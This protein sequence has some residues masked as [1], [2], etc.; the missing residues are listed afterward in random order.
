MFIHPN[1]PPFIHG[2]TS[3]M[4]TSD[5]QEVPFNQP[6]R[7]KQAVT[8]DREKLGTTA[9]LLQGSYKTSFT[10]GQIISTEL[11]CSE[12]KEETFPTNVRLKRQLENAAIES[13]FQ[14]RNNRISEKGL[15][16]LPPPTQN[17][18]RQFFNALKQH[19]N[20]KG[21]DIIMA[22]CKQNFQKKRFRGL[23]H[24]FEL[25]VDIGLFKNG[26]YLKKSEL[27][28][29]IGSIVKKF[30]QLQWGGNWLFPRRMHIGYYFSGRGL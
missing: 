28:R 19:F 12:E 1:N 7:E 30:P 14:L 8:S 20:A 24:M 4:I 10:S 22:P 23:E 15:Q 17:L 29:E 6:I 25:G 9:T 21:I 13:E 18:F 27:Y 2:K 16:A 11:Y 3:W 26:Y 5:S